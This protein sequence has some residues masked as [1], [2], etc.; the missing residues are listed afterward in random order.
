MGGPAAPGPEVRVQSRWP[1][2]G[3]GPRG[4]SGHCAA[5]FSGWPRPHPSAV[6]QG[7]RPFAH[8][9]ALDFLVTSAVMPQVPPGMSLFS[10]PQG[11]SQAGHSCSCIQWPCVPAFSP[12]V[13]GLHRHPLG[14]KEPS[15]AACGLSN[16]LALPQV[17]PCLD[18]GLDW[19]RIWVH[20]RSLRSQG[21]WPAVVSR[22]SP[23]AVPDTLWHVKIIACQFVSVKVLKAVPF[24]LRLFLHH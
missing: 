6:P 12:V 1:S 23:G 24:D 10:G 21:V 18:S 14:C 15:G 17:V 7:G 4:G 8:L 20:S 13:T 19:T 11:T 3:R 16:L 9:A 5:C 2:R 22:S